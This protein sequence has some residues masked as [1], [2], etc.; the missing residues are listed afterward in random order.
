[1]EIRRPVRFTA[2]QSLGKLAKWLRILGFD[3]AIRHFDKTAVS[4][5]PLP[6]RRILLT[7]MTRLK[8]LPASVFITSNDPMRQLKQVI[9]DMRITRNDIRLLTRCAECNRE[10]TSIDKAAVFTKV[11][12]YIWQ[13]HR[14]FHHCPECGRIFWPG[15]HARRA[16]ARIETLLFPHE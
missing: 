11:P 9:R 16:R 6:E 10:L 3:A 4:D 13:H 5:R 7:R 14:R 8:H 2:D 12:D 1:M 15:S